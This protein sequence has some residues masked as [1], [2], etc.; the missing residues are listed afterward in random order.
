MKSSHNYGR[1][2]CKFVVAWKVAQRYSCTT[3]MNPRPSLQQLQQLKPTLTSWTSTTFPRSSSWWPPIIYKT[4]RK[5]SW[6]KIIK[7]IICRCWTVFFSR[8]FL[9]IN[10]SII[11]VLFLVLWELLQYYNGKDGT[12]VY[13][14]YIYLCSLTVCQQ[15]PIYLN[16][17]YY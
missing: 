3:I 10:S 2:L 12:Q 14:L 17:A 8:L 13:N 1:L 6:N 4:K 7:T 11:I 5:H 15:N 9:I 16:R